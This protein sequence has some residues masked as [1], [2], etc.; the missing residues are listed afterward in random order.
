MSGERSSVSA[1]IPVYNGARFL[2]EAVASIRRQRPRPREIIIV[3]GGSTDGSWELAAGFGGEVR[4]ARQPGK[5]LADA[6][7]YGV[8]LA[9]GDIIA[10]LDC[11]DLWSDDKLTLQLPI[12]TEHRSID[13]V[14]GHTRRTWTSLAGAGQAPTQHLTEPSLALSFSAS[15]VR[16]SLFDEVGPCDEALSFCDDWDWFMRARERGVVIVAHPEV[17]LFYRRH[18]DNLSNRLDESKRE[19]ARMLKRSLARRGAHGVTASL[20]SMMSLVDYLRSETHGNQGDG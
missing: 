3:D 8:Q 13:I 14:L 11:D 20:P 9:A 12:L 2:G 10:F 15:L 4:P 17:T 18:G 1:V 19:F 7:N 6:R 5:G 16:R